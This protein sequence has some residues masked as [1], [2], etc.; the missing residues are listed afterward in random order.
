MR[1]IAGA[2]LLGAAFLLV[3]IRFEHREVLG[4]TW[5]GWIPLSYAA[6]L[7]AAGVPAWIAWTK[8]GRKVLA[9][10][11]ALAI[12]VGLLGAWFH[13]DGRPDKSLARVVRVWAVAPGK[14]GRM[15]HEDAPPALAP[16]A[17]CG[18]GLLG[19]LSCTSDG[20]RGPAREY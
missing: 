5:R 2:L 18:L 10:L 7:L 17:F 3:E 20:S 15:K 13:S 6:L 8:G 12:A 19:L 9:A 16:M 1:R 14:D 4:E 11:F